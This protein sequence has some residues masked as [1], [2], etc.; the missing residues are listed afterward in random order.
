MGKLFPYWTISP[1][2]WIHPG[3]GGEKDSETYDACKE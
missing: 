2:F 1:L 3:L